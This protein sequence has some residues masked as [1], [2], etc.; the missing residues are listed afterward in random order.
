[1]QFKKANTE[2]KFKKILFPIFFKLTGKKRK[3]SFIKCGN[4]WSNCSYSYCTI[5]EIKINNTEFL[6]EMFYDVK[7]NYYFR[8]TLH[9][10]TYENI[11]KK[12]N[13]PYTIEDNM[14]KIDGK[15]VKK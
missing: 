12:F 8:N 5:Y 7:N 1:M 13:I 6:W 11:F 15:Y 14:I 9:S 10:L 4:N 3:S 2:E